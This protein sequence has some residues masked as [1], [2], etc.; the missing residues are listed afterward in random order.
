MFK[1]ELYDR[2]GIKLKLGDVVKISNGK[3]FNYYAEVTYLKGEGVITPFHTFSFHSFE[4]VEEMPKDVIKLNEE[5]YNIWYGLSPEADKEQ[6][7]KEATYYLQQW[8]E[9]EHLLN[10]RTF[11]IVEE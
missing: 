7:V 9:V 6:A 4:K 2:K 1:L 10:N 3:H 11:R 5:R 8:R